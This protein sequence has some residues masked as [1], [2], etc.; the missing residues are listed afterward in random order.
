VNQR[1]STIRWRLKRCKCHSGSSSRADR[2]VFH[3]W[4]VVYMFRLAG[5][6]CLNT[7]VSI[8]RCR[9]LPSRHPWCHQ[10]S[11][12]TDDARTLS[13]VCRRSLPCQTA[14]YHDQWTDSRQGWRTRVFY[15]P[16]WTRMRSSVRLWVTQVPASF[17]RSPVGHRLSIISTHNILSLI[18]WPDDDWR[19]D[20]RVWRGLKSWVWSA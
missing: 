3:S 16:T 20:T 9:W 18:H 2:L 11:G 17:Y 15:R 13:I 12:A 6:R 4:H 7:S 14:T 1:Q 5:R 19:C 8:R 10:S